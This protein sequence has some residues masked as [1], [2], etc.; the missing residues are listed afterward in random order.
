MAKNQSEASDSSDES[1]RSAKAEGDHTPR[2]YTPREQFLFGV[3]LFAI[4]ALLI[5]LLWLMDK[6]V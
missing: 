2:T 6:Y 1:S 3:K 4:A 5:L